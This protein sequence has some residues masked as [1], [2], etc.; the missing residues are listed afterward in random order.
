MPSRSDDMSDDGGKKMPAG[1]ADQDSTPAE[2]GGNN[3][4]TELK[5]MLAW[6]AAATPEQRQV[7]AQLVAGRGG[8]PQAPQQSPA[9]AYRTPQKRVTVLAPGEA[10]MLQEGGGLWEDGWID[11]G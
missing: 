9:A 3:L 5:N 4:P 1:G 8:T 11:V 6:A 10:S 7:L 2:G